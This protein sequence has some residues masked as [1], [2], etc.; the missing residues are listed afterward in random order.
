MKKS[1]LKELI[2]EEIL[3]VLLTELSVEDNKKLFKNLMKKVEDLHIEY[4]K[5][6]KRPGLFGIER[7]LEK[8]KNMDEF[9]KIVN[10]YQTWSKTS[11]VAK[12]YKD[13]ID[14]VDMLP[15]RLQRIFRSQL[16][17]VSKE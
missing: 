7:R 14:T 15:S 11:K 16:L 1:E 12:T 2:K 6:G 4:T 8:F 13:L 5:S 3:Y 9:N 10:W 17:N